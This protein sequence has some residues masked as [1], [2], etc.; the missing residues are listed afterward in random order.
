MINTAYE[1]VIDRYLDLIQCE[2][3]E[4][5][6]PEESDNKDQIIIHFAKNTF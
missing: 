5:A 6:R 4:N 1:I 2:N 3:G